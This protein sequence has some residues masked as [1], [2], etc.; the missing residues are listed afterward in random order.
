LPGDWQEGDLEVFPEPD[1]MQGWPAASTAI[2]RV[3]VA[4]DGSPDSVA[5]LRTAAA[6]IGG[7]PGHIV[8]FGV[9]PESVQ[10]EAELDD[11]GVELEAIRRAAEAFESA[12][13][14]I[15]PNFGARMTLHT[16]PGR[17]VARAVC[18]YASEQGFDLLVVGRHGDGGILHPRLGHIAKAA[19]TDS[20]IPVLLVSA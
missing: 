9:L 3:L 16:E 6:I 7:A 17:H 15:A 2:R 20:K 5:A 1:S 12:R 10:P 8:A 19:A 14:T 11:P 13:A 18:D 4:W